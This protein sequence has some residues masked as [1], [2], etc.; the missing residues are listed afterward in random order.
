MIADRKPLSGTKTHPLKPGAIAVLQELTR[1]PAPCSQINPGVRDRLTRESLVEEIEL[2]SPFAK[3][4][5]API[6]HLQINDAG[7]AALAETQ[8]G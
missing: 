8:K 3:N 1:R 7:R 6:P 5:G 4:K 2:P